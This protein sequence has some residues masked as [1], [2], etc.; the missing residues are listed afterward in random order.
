M[1]ALEMVTLEAATEPPVPFHLITPENVGNE[2][3]D[4]IGPQLLVK[5]PEVVATR[6]PLLRVTPPPDVPAPEQFVNFIRRVT[7]SALE[8]PLTSFGENFI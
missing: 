8:P 6:V 2:E 3:P 4:M 1:S 5:G 7:A